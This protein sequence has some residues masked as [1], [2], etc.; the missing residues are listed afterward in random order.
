MSFLDES[1]FRNNKN[2]SNFD[3]GDDDELSNQFGNRINL[4]SASGS[5]ARMLAQ[6]REKQMKK[7]QTNTANEGKTT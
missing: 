4:G 5:R 1:D 7:R 3:N 6:E 2:S